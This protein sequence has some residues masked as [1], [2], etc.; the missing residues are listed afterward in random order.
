[1]S[2]PTA[3]GRMFEVH[4]FAATVTG[5]TLQPGDDAARV[6]YLGPVLPNSPRG[7]VEGPNL[8]V[9]SRRGMVTGCM[10]TPDG[11]AK[12]ESW[13]HRILRWMLDLLSLT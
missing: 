7:V 13:S 10:N 4:D 9:G 3:D 5:D 11:K 12:K 6:P 1:M 2:I 8:Q